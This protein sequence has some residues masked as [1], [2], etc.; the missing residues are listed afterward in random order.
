MFTASTIARAEDLRKSALACLDELV[1]NPMSSIHEENPHRCPNLFIN[2]LS[3]FPVHEW[4][5]GWGAPIFMGRPPAGVGMIYTVP[6]S[7]T[8]HDDA[9]L[10]LIAGLETPHMKLFLELIRQKPASKI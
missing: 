8:D 9:G 3:R 1:T 4:D 6:P 10:P 2:K 5:F 7:S